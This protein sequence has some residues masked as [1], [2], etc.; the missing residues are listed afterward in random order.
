MA[1]TARETIRAEISALFDSISEVQDNI[2]YPPLELKGQ[3]P[4]ISTHTGGTRPTFT[5]ASA[6]EIYH[7]FV[8][9]VYVNREA[10]GASGAETLLDQI[11]MKVLQAIRDDVSGTSYMTLAVS[12]RSEPDFAV[13]DG[14]QYRVEE[15]TVEARTN[16]SG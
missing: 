3:S 11:V 14:I 5:S 6:N 4:V 15:I 10:H 7:S 13:I 12:G 1:L 2:A 9:T 8:V 16:G